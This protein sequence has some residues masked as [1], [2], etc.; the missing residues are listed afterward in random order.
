[1]AY[2]LL[3]DIVV[4]V[5]FCFVLFVVFGGLLLFRWPLLMWLHIP[6]AIWG[7]VIEF[8]GWACPLTPLENY[9]WKAGGKGGYRTDFVQHYLTSV[10][11]PDLLTREIQ[12][13]LGFT[14]L[15]VNLLVYWCVFSRPRHRR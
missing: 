6:A 1:M 9:L 7:I 4:V 12:I 15:S 10:L 2:R 8:A 14:A 13:I 11:Y 3:A 5:H